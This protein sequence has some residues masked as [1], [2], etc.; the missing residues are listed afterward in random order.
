MHRTKPNFRHIEC[1][2][3][4]NGQNIYLTH[5]HN[6]LLNVKSKVTDTQVYSRKKHCY[7]IVASFPLWKYI[8]YEFGTTP[9]IKINILSA[10][11]VILVA[12]WFSVVIL[13]MELNT[14]KYYPGQFICSSVCHRP[15]C[16]HIYTK[17]SRNFIPTGQRSISCCQAHI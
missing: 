16:S 7:I 1:V 15:L 17:K 2:T 10:V 13:P 8:S 14:T 5:L 12:R 11:F 9:S 4:F 6:S 3:H